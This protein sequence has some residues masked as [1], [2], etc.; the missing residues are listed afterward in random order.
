MEKI[1]DIFATCQMLH[2]SDSIL[3][4][5]LFSTLFNIPFSP[6]VEKQNL[7]AYLSFKIKYAKI[8]KYVI[9]QINYF[10]DEKTIF[11]ACHIFK[12]KTLKF[13][14]RVVQKVSFP[15]TKKRKKA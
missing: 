3:S 2:T 4:P 12:K 7:N 15:L 6:L 13:R 11:I 10:A 8:E 1:S 5:P 14:T 9:C